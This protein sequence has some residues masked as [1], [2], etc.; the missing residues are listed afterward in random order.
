MNRDPY[1][2][3]VV[4]VS[5]RFA[6]IVYSAIVRPY[7]GTMDHI[8]EETADGPLSL[9]EH[10]PQTLNGRLTVVTDR[11]HEPEMVT[12]QKRLIVGTRY[13]VTCWTRTTDW[14]WSVITHQG[15]N[16]D[17]TLSIVSCWAQTAD[18]I[19][20]VFTRR[21]RTFV[22]TRS[23]VTCRLWTGVWTRFAVTCR[24]RT[25]YSPRLSGRRSSPAAA[26]RTARR[27]RPSRVAASRTAR[28]PPRARAATAAACGWGGRERSPGRRSGRGAR[29]PCSR[30]RRWRGAA[31]SATCRRRPAGR[32]LQ[33][34][35]R[36]YTQDVVRT[37]RQQA[38]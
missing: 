3:A 12:R 24:R 31:A 36:R 23:V 33:Q 2:I 6:T 7:A 9:V 29:T 1:K 28:S 20:S 5:K 10:G 15:Q 25:V 14:T 8:L 38:W 26:R 16:V 19:W 22:C 35:R 13:V 32:P 27:G 21:R 37:V 34:P 4:G 30:V 11:Q 17:W 18:Q